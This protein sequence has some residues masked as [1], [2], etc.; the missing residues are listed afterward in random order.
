[1]ERPGIAVQLGG[2]R[3]AHAPAGFEVGDLLVRQRLD[4]PCFEARIGLVC[5]RPRHLWGE[6]Q[7]SDCGQ[8]PFVHDNL[9]RCLLRT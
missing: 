4:R 5:L 1:M 2:Q 9:L 6:K 8:Y 3:E 7:G